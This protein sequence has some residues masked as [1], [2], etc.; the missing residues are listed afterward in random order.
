MSIREKLER[1]G[2]DPKKS[3]GQNF[4]VERAMIE[5]MA[6]AANVNADDTVLEV[7]AGLGDL[8]AIL[9]ARARRVIAL[10]ID[11]RFLD[12][13]EV[14]FANQPGVE[15][16]HAD[17]LKADLPDLLGSDYGSYKV[18][19]NVPYYITSAILRKLLEASTPPEVLVI[20]VQWE[21]AERAIAKPGDMSLLALGVQVY[22]VPEIV[23][24]LKPGVFYPRPNIDSA[25][26][27]V[28]PHPEG[29]PLTAE[30]LTGLF[31]VAQ[32]GF[33]QPR[34]QIKNP[35]ATGLHM[36]KDTAS[37]ALNT[38]GIDPRRRAETLTIPEWIALYRV[39]QDHL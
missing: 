10:E 31:R 35:L 23:K 12:L 18:V 15:V 14:D 20:T 3:L 38:A 21:V 36:D 2:G 29:P 5:L 37:D 27:K 22:G 25:I 19:A 28:T 24:K 16:V 39:L 32:A 8:T 34:K 33:S 9:A 6:D 11:Q 13:L 4:M 26:L 30:E 1:I 17:I 7:G